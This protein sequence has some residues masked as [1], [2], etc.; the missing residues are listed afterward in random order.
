MK[1][2]VAQTIEEQGWGPMLKVVREMP[3]DEDFEKWDTPMSART[4]SASGITPVPNGCRPFRW[5]NVW[6]TRTARSIPL[7]A[8]EGGLPRG[9]WRGEDFCQRFKATLSEKDMAI[10]ELR[11]EGYTFGEIADK[12]GYK[13][14]SARGQAHGGDQEAVLSSTRRKQGGKATQAGKRRAWLFLYPKCETGQCN[15]L[16]VENALFSRVSDPRNRGGLYPIIPTPG[17]GETLST[18]R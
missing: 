7:P 4:S 17:N 11:V 14:H 1:L 2:V 18:R 10:L 12:L 5:R 3:C 6:R 15:H 16:G 13:T 9:R 8:P